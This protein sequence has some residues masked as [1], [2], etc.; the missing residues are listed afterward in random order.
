MNR[1]IILGNVGSDPKFKDL[2]DNQVVNFSVAVSER[3]KSGDKEKSTDW[4]HVVAWNQIA[5]F[6]EKYT[7]KGAKIMIEGKMRTRTFEKD[8]S[9]RLVW[10]LIADRVELI[11]WPSE[12]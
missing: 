11:D 4:F 12:D 8:G 7:R 3:P 9:E 5:L 1:T 2:G 6:V 10:E